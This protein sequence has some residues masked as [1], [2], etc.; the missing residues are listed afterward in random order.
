MIFQSKSVARELIMYVS[1]TVALLMGIAAYISVSQLAEAKRAYAYQVLDSQLEKNTF[2]IKSFFEERGRIV[3]SVF[4]SPF[5]K[6]WFEQYTERGSDISQDPTYLKFTQHFK[7]FTEEDPTVKAVFFAPAKTFEYFD[8]NGRYNNDTYFTYKRP[9]WKEAHDIGRFF[10]SKP[11]ID[12]VD[13]TVVSAVKKPILDSNGEFLGFGGIDILIST[14]GK[15]VL[16]KM[17]YEGQGEAFMIADDGSVVFF[18]NEGKKFDEGQTLAS[19]DEVF[20][21]MA[22]GFE[23]LQSSMKQ[24]RYGR[25]EVTWRSEKHVVAYLPVSS[26]QPYFNW[27]LGIMV[28]ENAIEGPIR[29]SILTAV[30]LVLVILLIV[31]LATGYITKRIISPLGDLVSTMR[32]IASGEG[33]LTQRLHVNRQDELGQLSEQFNLFIGNI[34]TIIQQSKEVVSEVDGSAKHVVETIDKA[35]K[36]ATKQKL[37]L[38]MIAAASTEMSQTV[39]EISLGTRRTTEFAVNADRQ[40]THGQ[41]IVEESTKSIEELSAAVYQAAEVV[42]KLY[43]DSDSI[44]QV[45]EVI[46]AIAEQTNLL[47]LNAAIEAAR[48]GEQGRGF[49]VVADEVRSLAQRTQESTQNIQNIIE[50]LQQNAKDAVTV[51]ENGQTKAEHGVSKAI[52]VKEVLFEIASCIGEIQSQAEEID[53]ATNEQVKTSEEITRNVVNIKDLADA[54]VLQATE[55]ADVA[56]KQQQTTQQLSTIINRFKA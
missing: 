30:V 13:G 56:T 48:A 14:L 9:W 44:G 27:R 16:S 2:V 19:M 4:S 25:G 32:E 46:R 52:A 47:A 43:Q 26:E 23:Q 35:S 45:L 24:G 8:P 20:K 5:V 31:A 38:E 29:N 3:R 41:S 1:F 15:E 53:T 34:Q 18:P 55:V 22:G 50:G 39:Q 21:D 49:A 6:D 11:A 12:Y 51:M 37:E 40:A 10:A 7:F 42:Q 54:T 28:P 33:D 17:K 36:G